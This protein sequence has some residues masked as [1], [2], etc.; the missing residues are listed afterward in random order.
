MEKLI[1]C[2]YDSAAECYMDPFVAPTVHF[3]I[4][5][6][7]EAVNKKGHQFNTFPEDYTLFQ[8]GS[9]NA[10]AGVITP[11]NPHSLGVA[12]TYL[13]KEITNG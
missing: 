2:V 10:E 8:I 7:R 3:A 13:D 1:F 4:R 9:Y 12:I 5:G 11:E 6:F